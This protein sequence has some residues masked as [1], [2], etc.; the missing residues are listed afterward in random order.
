[1]PKFCIVFMSFSFSTIN[2]TVE[3][4]TLKVE[5]KTIKII[6]RETIIFSEFIILYKVSFNFL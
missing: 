5:I 6:I 2:I 4:I 1:M 3:A